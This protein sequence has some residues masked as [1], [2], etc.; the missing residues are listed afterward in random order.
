MRGWA[1]R[2]PVLRMVRIVSDIEIAMQRCVLGDA[3]GHGTHVAAIAAGGGRVPGVAPAADIAVVSSRDFRRLADAVLFLVELAMQRAQPLVVNISVGAHYGLHDG[4]TPLEKFLGRLQARGRVFVSAA[5]N[6]GQARMHVQAELTAEWQRVGLENL[7]HGHRDSVAYRVI[8]VR[9]VRR[10]EVGLEYWQD[11]QRVAV[12]PFRGDADHVAEHRWLHAGQEIGLIGYEAQWHS[13]HQAVRRTVF[14]DREQGQALPDGAQLV[15]ALRGEGEVHAW[16]GQSNYQWGWAQFAAVQEDGWLAG[17]AQRS[18][19]VPATA[20]P[21]IAVGAYNARLQWRSEA[22]HMLSVPGQLGD[23][24]GFSSQGPTHDAD[25]TGLKPDLAAPGCWIASARGAAVVAV[26]KY[27]LTDDTVLMQGTSMA[28]PHVSG[29][30]ALMLE[31]QASL[32]SSDVREVLADT[33]VRDV[34]TGVR[35]NE[36]WGHGKLNA[37][38]AVHMAE[39]RRGASC[40]QSASLSLWGWLMGWLMGAISRR[41]L[42]LLCRAR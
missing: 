28:A 33:A 3:L 19:T 21:V 31:A 38:G 5:G 42:S 8:G 18:I 27:V 37:Q 41:F 7:L 22:G 13:E 9:A 15:L 23:L 20:G 36:R 14:I 2:L 6:D 10:L 30:A 40:Q 29:V 25:F 1:P 16:A 32:R 39:A 12:V 34:F 26:G 11:G 17:D 24:A 4:R 35:S